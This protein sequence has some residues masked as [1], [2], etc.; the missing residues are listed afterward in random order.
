MRQNDAGEGGMPEVGD[1]V[2]VRVM[3]VDHLG[4]INLSGKLDDSG[5]GTYKER[6][7]KGRSNQNRSKD[8]PRNSGKP[9]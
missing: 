5:R 2:M 3:E 9:R 1:E 4:R 7:G 6:S 8:R